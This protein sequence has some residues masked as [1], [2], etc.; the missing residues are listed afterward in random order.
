MKD[1]ESNFALNLYF[2][3]IISWFL[4]LGTRIPPLGAARIDLLLVLILFFLSLNK[5]NNY[6]DIKTSK[7]ILF[8]VFYIIA[9]VPLVQWPGSV[10]KFGIGNFIKAI[11]FYFFTIK[12]I[13]T[14]ERLKRFLHVFIACMCFRVLEPLYLN[15]TSGYWGE[16]AYMQGE[17][18]QR[19]AGAPS[20]IIGANGLAFVILIIFP[21]LYYLSFVAKKYLFISV[22]LFFPLVYALTLTGSRSGMLG[23]IIFLIFLI[24]KS[25][26]KIILSC[27]GLVVMA[28]IFIN[29]S[30]D[31]QDRYLSIVDS[32]KK[33]A[34]T[35]EGRVEGVKADFQ[36]AMHRPLFGHGLGTSREANFNIGGKNQISHN[37]YAET[38]QE[39]G[40]VGLFIFLLYITSIIGNYTKTLNIMRS[41]AT[42]GSRFLFEVNNSLF[43]WLGVNLF[44]S[45]ASYGL[46]SFEWY[47]F[48]GISVAL[49]NIVSNPTS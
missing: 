35:S 2:L 17:F 26:K 48:G 28:V 49:R 42:T 9:T 18:M 44:F 43:V 11:V 13:D 23:F 4:H 25:K 3:F 31:Q 8:L 12:F 20:D 36:V 38:A 22:I 7:I 10:L 6:T 15:L 45:M 27:L 32:S 47:L 1:N 33:N 39:I 41:S 34:A 16:A 14:E 29:L 37:L 40:F 5:R 30:P 21:F 46:S 19:L 24:L